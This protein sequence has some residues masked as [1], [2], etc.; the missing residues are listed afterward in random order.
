MVSKV[1]PTTKTDPPTN[2]DLIATTEAYMLAK[3]AEA[4]SNVEAST[5]AKIVE[6]TSY[7]PT[8]GKVVLTVIPYPTGI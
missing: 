7:V 5:P 4:S 1:I 2:K 8:V 3:I 6:A